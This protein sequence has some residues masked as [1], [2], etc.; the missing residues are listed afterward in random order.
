MPDRTDSSSFGSEAVTSEELTGNAMIRPWSFRPLVR[1]MISMSWVEQSAHNPFHDTETPS[2]HTTNPPFFDFVDSVPPFVPKTRIRRCGGTSQVSQVTIHPSHK[3]AYS[4]STD[5]RLDKPPEPLYAA[6]KQ[7]HVGNDDDFFREAM[8]L[9]HLA[10]TPHPHIVPLLASYREKSQYHLVFPWANCDLATF[11][12]LHPRPPHDIGWLLL[13]MKG[14]ANALSFLHRSTEKGEIVHGDLKPE[15]ILVFRDAP[16][17]HTLAITDFGSSYFLPSDG[18]ENTKPRNIKRTPAYRAPEVD[19][20]SEGVTP[21]YDIWGLGCIFSQAL[22]WTLDGLQG[23]ERLSEARRDQED[24]SPNRDAFFRLQRTLDGVL[25]ARLKPQVQNLL[26]SMR[27]HPHSTPFSNDILDLVVNGMLRIDLRQRMT[28]HE[29]AIALAEI[30]KRLDEDPAYSEFHVDR[31]D[32]DMEMVH[33]NQ[34]ASQ[35]PRLDRTVD[36]NY[37]TN[38]TTQSL[39]GYHDQGQLKPRFACPFFKAGIRVSAR[40]RACEGPGWTD[41]NKV[42]EHIFRTHLVDH[43]K[44]KFVCRRCDEGFKTDE[45]FLAHQHQELACHKITS[46]PAYGKLTREQASSLRSLKRKSTK[47]SD[48]ERWFEIYKLVNP[49]SD[50]RLDGISPSTKILEL[51]V[52]DIETFDGARREPIFAYEITQASCEKVDIAEGHDAQVPREHSPLSQLLASW[53]NNEAEGTYKI[54]RTDGFAYIFLWNFNTSQFYMTTADPFSIDQ[55]YEVQK[56]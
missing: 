29:V 52:K 4:K 11:W 38:T 16:E 23:L 37:Y 18:K 19:I 12:R 14:I 31:G 26:L 46:Q 15:N 54:S 3:E 39:D 21:A 17:R 27:N 7:F 8:N 25:T 13:Q 5:N 22:L 41:I 36:A 35:R 2:Q 20:T 45:L 40:H 56:L 48:E 9:Q 53:N 32:N 43:H 42:K 51:Q 55:K 24:N 47:I 6:L 44:N 50:P 30:C 34:N 28:S 49:S 33:T 10:Q 1:H